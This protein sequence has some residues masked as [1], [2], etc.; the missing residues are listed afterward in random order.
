MPLTQLDSLVEAILLADR[1]RLYGRKGREVRAF[2][3]DH[4]ATIQVHLNKGVR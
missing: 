4:D 3:L 2:A 1:L